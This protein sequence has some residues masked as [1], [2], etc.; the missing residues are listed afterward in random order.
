MKYH[1]ADNNEPCACG[2]VSKRAITDH[3]KKYF[4]C[5]DCRKAEGIKNAIKF[6]HHRIAYRRSAKGRAKKKEYRQRAELA[7]GG[8]FYA[9]RILKSIG[10]YR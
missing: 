1:K 3:G 5:I 9:D 4:V 8:Q 2:C 6:K 10:Y 7:A